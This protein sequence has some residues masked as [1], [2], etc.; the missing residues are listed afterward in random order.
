[1]AQ[2]FTLKL[3]SVDLSPYV[4]LAPGEGFDPMDGDGFLNPAFTPAPLGEGQL[5]GNVSVDDRQMAWPL[6]LNALS[7]D[8]VHA[9]VA[10]INNEIA[11]NPSLTVEWKDQG[12]SNSTFY[13][14]A[15][16]RFDPE[17]NYR[18][19]ALNWESGTLHI[20][21]APPYGHTGTTRVVA[22]G[23]TPSG[24]S[25]VAIV[26]LASIIGDAPALLRTEIGDDGQTGRNRPFQNI[27]AV[28]VL[29][30]PSYVSY[31]PAASAPRVLMGATLGAASWAYGSQALYSV[32]Q[33]LATQ[34][35]CIGNF[36]LPAA[37]M[38]SGRHR[39]FVLAGAIASAVPS[40]ANATM[41][42][43]A[44]SEGSQVLGP[45]GVF[46]TSA[47]SASFNNR[48]IDLGVYSTPTYTPSPMINVFIGGA[49]NLGVPSIVPCVMINGL[50]VLPEDTMT[51]VDL[52]ITPMGMWNASSP[53]GPA[54]DPYSASMIFDGTGHDDV[55]W[56]TIRNI[57]NVISPISYNVDY[58]RRG[59]IARL[60]PTPTSTLAV[61]AHEP[62]VNGPV[63]GNFFPWH[64][65]PVPFKIS[66]RE[67]FQ[68]A[69]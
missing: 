39:V 27:R 26:P 51:Y 52:A 4:R 33:A 30:H 43:Y 49:A 31:I 10:S 60:Q 8:A 16:A 57:A 61:V 20:W 46:Q 21:C 14:V 62:G 22:T 6:H 32:T 50:I 69:R 47:P 5:L 41:C 29:P 40:A 56:T 23:Q 7:K 58:L 66:A 2:P 28:A 45:T 67:R 55:S 25:P 19:S 53:L 9:L 48:M 11:N 18:R 54:G 63:A 17:Y 35:Q 59:G 65:S 36:P 42:V 12:A 37:T 24:V 13:D 68:F 34:A 15:F 3:G 1:M 64:P 38:Y 44:Q